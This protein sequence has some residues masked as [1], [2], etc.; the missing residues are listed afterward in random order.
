M[1]P[2]TRLELDWPDGDTTARDREVTRRTAHGNL[3]ATVFG[4]GARPIEAGAEHDCYTCADNQ[5]RCHACGRPLYASEWNAAFGGDLADFSHAVAEWEHEHGELL[6]PGAEGEPLSESEPA[7]QDWPP[8]AAQTGDIEVDRGARVY[9]ARWC[10]GVWR[11]DRLGTVVIDALR[12]RAARPTANGEPGT[13]LPAHENGPDEVPS[14]WAVAAKGLRLR[15]GAASRRVDSAIA[16]LPT[17]GCTDE[18]DMRLLELLT[19]ALEAAAGEGERLLRLR[20]ER[21][22]AERRARQLERAADALKSWPT[23]PAASC[24]WRSLLPS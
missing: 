8:P 21:R 22:H 12:W 16:G 2:I 17:P 23:E 9:R 13:A 3:D 6:E 15:I 19:D 1:D 10:D 4:G 24:G 14:P 11:W 20:G 18:A 5:G 7:W